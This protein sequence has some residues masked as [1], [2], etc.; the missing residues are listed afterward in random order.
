MDYLENNSIV[1]HCNIFKGFSKMRKAD[2]VVNSY[3]II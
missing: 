3:K 2:R 1:K